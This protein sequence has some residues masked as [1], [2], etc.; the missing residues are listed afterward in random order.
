MF[1]IKDFYKDILNDFQKRFNTSKYVI[2]RLLP[3][4]WN[5]KLIG[6]MKDELDR[7]IIR[8]KFK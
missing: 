3:K 7:K 8:L 5:K 6:L 1:R 2:E 4:G